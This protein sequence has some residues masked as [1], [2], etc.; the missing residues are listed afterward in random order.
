MPSAGDRITV[1]RTSER[2][3]VVCPG[4]WDSVEHFWNWF[5][6]IGQR[7]RAEVMAEERQQT[8]RPVARNF[9]PALTTSNRTLIHAR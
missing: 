2:V 3:E 9:R 8:P 6:D 7:A 5:L 1:G 4:Q